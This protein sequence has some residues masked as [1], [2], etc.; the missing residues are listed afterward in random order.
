M[1][2]I[3]SVVHLLSLCPLS[4]ILD[5]TRHLEKLVRALQW[6]LELCSVTSNASGSDFLSLS[7]GVCYQ[8]SGTPNM[9]P[10]LKSAAQSL[11]C[12]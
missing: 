10:F 5:L 11:V 7:L 8:D 2:L 1:A 6:L 9:D 4:G 12:K 3:G